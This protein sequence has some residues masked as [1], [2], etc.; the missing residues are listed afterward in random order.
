MRRIMLVLLLFSGFG[1]AVMTLTRELEAPEHVVPGQPVRVA[2]TFWTDS[3]FNPPPVWPEMMIANGTLLTTSLPNQLV[4]RREGNASWSGIKMERQLMAWDSGM[5]RLPAIDVTLI[6]AGQ[7]P[8]TVTLP[9]LEKQ[10]SWPAS[11][12]Q[13]DRFLPASALTLQQKLQ[14]WR[15]D[16]DRPIHVGDVIERQVT[17]QAQ[18]VIPA[19]IPQILF[20][21]PGSGTQ[22]LTPVNSLLTQSR[23]EVTGAQRVERLRYLPTRAGTL[24]LPEVKLRWWDTSQQQWQLTS[25]P[26]ATYTIAPARASG[27][28]NALR[29]DGPNSLWPLAMLAVAVIFLAIVGWL[30]RHALW[31]IGRFVIQRGLRIWCIVPLPDLATLKRK[32]T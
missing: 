15:A 4:S 20:S 19:Q 14:V 5:L 25:L 11:V 17:V 16:G 10:V 2:L 9:A 26:G 13:P 6:S 24:T 18:D 1:Q 3:W 8:R 31:R 29:A 22:R 30:M 28:E 27:S 12:Q 7:P 23:G 21:I 32:K